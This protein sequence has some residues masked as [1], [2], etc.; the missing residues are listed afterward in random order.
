MACSAP[1]SVAVA[2]GVV[3]AAAAAAAAAAV[4][5]VATQLR[6]VVAVCSKEVEDVVAEVIWIY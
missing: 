5:V 6:K 3:A 2:V 1:L 4:V